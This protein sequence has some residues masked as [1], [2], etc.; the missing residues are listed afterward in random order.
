MNQMIKKIYPPEKNFIYK[1]DSL[2][3]NPLLIKHSKASKPLY[4]ANFLTSFDGRIATFNKKNKLLLTPNKIKNDVDFSLFCQLHAQSDCLVTNTQY[5]NGLNKGHYGDILS[6]NN[7]TLEKWRLKNNLPEQKII[8]LSNSLNFPINK[9]IE[10]YKNQITI[11]TTSNE[12]KKINRFIEKKYNIVKYKGNNITPAILNNF[13][14]KNKL[15]SIY[16]IAGPRIVEQMISKNLLDKL[17]CSVSMGLVGTDN[18]DKIIR[19]DYL[20]KFTNLNLQ[21]MYIGT[22]NNNKEKMQTLYQVFNLKGK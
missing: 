20:K 10:K 17:Y 9:I 13:I 21:E 6:I 8:I 1:V 3:L 2:Y 22:K 15:R 4:Y 5:I 18:Y 19:G 11:L 14:L 12:F 7:K 16:F